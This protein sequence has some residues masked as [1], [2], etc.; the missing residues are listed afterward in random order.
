MP[1]L[2]EGQTPTIEMIQEDLKLNP[3]GQGALDVE[4]DFAYNAPFYITFLLAELD[5]AKRLARR[6]VRRQKK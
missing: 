6:R 2:E 3:P 1:F 5:H 4:I